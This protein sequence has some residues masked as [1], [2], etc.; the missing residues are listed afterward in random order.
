MPGKD[1]ANMEKSELF[2][3]AI[4]ELTEEATAKRRENMDESE[5]RLCDE[6]KALRSQA[7]KIV[8]SLL[9]DKYN[10]CK[11]YKCKE[12]LPNWIGKLFYKIH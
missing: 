10:K 3:N 8:Q 11:L 5:Q 9:E 1:M 4:W 12:G 6:V 7:Q 2:E